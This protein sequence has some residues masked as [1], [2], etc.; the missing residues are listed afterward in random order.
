MEKFYIVGSAL[1]SVI[2]TV[3][4]YAAGQY[5]CVIPSRSHANCCL[6][7]SFSWRARW[8]PL[9]KDC[10]YTNDNKAQRLAWQV[11]LLYLRHTPSF[12]RLD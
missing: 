6:C 12:V 9:E 4:A 1:M 3:P 8:D 5:G 7:R 2:L 10:W 11:R